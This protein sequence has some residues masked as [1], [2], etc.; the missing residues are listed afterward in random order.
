MAFDRKECMRKWRAKNKE[1]VVA[2]GMKYRAAN[3]EK[4]IE[5]SEKYREKNKEKVTASLKKYYEAN[6]EKY[7]ERSKK[8]WQKIKAV[9][10]LNASNE[11]VELLPL[12]REKDTHTSK[13]KVVKHGECI[14]TDMSL[15][16][17][18]TEIILK[19]EEVVLESFFSK[20]KEVPV[21]RYPADQMALLPSSLKEAKGKSIHYYTGKPCPRGHYAPRYSVNG[22]CMECIRL[23]KPTDGMTEYH[24]QYTQRRLD[25]IRKY[26]EILINAGIEIRNTNEQK[27]TDRMEAARQGKIFYFD[28]TPCRKGHADKLR[29]TRNGDCVVCARINSKKR[30]D[31]L[32]K[33]DVVI[34]NVN[35]LANPTVVIF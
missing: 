16:A 6:K 9:K 24:K 26:G 2:Y 4:E 18:R 28:P 30:N 13:R 5:R 23:T 19:D 3:P 22:S 20:E 1:K 35:L 10:L 15:R 29:Y 17:D 33:K 32:T 34:D 14:R 12:L 7:I 27:I 21:E 8:Q 31:R 25:E 11:P